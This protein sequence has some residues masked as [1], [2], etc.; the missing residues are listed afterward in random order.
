VSAAGAAIV[1]LLFGFI[2]IRYLPDIIAGMMPEAPIGAETAI[3]FLLFG[4]LAV[5]AIV[6]GWLQGVPVLRP[7]RRAATTALVALAAG[8]G[9][10]GITVAYSGFANA[11]VPEPRAAPALGTL[12]VGTLA[13]FIQSAGEEI[14]VRGWLQPVLGRAV[15][16]PLAIVAGSIIF[17]VLHLILG[18]G[19][20][21]TLLNLFI[22]GCWFGLLAWRTG[23][24]VAPIAAH[25][26]WN[27]AEAILFGLSPNPGVGPFG[28]IISLDMVGAAK[29]GGGPEG[30]N[31][32]IGTSIA[33]LA[34]CLPLIALRSR[35][36][37]MESP[38]AAASSP[39]ILVSAQPVAARNAFFLGDG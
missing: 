33:L 11:L 22:A 7:G 4:G 37:A 8:I 21:V 28:S 25:F 30:L 13:V 12:L 36:G 6:A 38:A 17:M 26:G 35:K 24:I 34:V 16:A 3:A 31:A 15:G 23:G 18:T 20:P 19:T 14:Y 39:T 10:L 9:T 27:W 32:S 5:L 1:A 2:M 29:W